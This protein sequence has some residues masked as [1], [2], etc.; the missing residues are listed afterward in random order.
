[1]ARLC[2]RGIVFL[3]AYAPRALAL[4]LLALVISAP[5]AS[6]QADRDL[7]DLV[8]RAMQPYVRGAGAAVVVRRRGQTSFFDFGD[9]DRAT[10]RRVSPDD[11]FN[12]ASVGKLFPAI[13]LAQAVER[14]EVS[15]DD[16]VANYVTELR[17]GG[18]IGRVTL[19]HLASHTSGLTRGPGEYE[20]W[21]RGKY[22]LP[23]FLRYLNAWRAEPG[24]APG[25][26][27]LYSNSAIVLLRL[28]LARRF[29]MPFASLMRERI[30][31]PLGMDS[32][33]LPLPA[34][35]RA[36]AVQGY[37]PA[38]RP[39]GKPGDQQGVLDFPGAGQV[40]SS[41]RDMAKFL[42]ANLGE[43]PGQDAI[44]RAMKRAQEPVF[45]V[46]PRFTQ[47][48]VWQRVRQGGVTLVDKNG[49]LNNVSTY[50]GLVPDRGLGVVILCN[51]GKIPATRLGRQILLALADEAGPASD[52][53]GDGD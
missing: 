39:I 27:N 6:A 40:H 23:D 29:D 49:A 26:Q 44:E 12:L 28:A 37:G 53:G 48:L 7:R 20:P 46:S 9:A 11:I 3:N 21:H 19:G 31:K 33:A 42:V 41:A 15:L 2:S 16:P 47:G 50:I 38:G 5:G 4:A 1:M 35:L 52:D 14:G 25:A 10:R 13:L 51:R 32:T 30:T 8:A 17:K 24:R 45:S 36:R 18:D 22:T 43:T 34:A